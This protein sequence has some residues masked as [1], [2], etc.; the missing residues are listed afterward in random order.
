MN[1]D[2]LKT[3]KMRWRAKI[4]PAGVLKGLLR[5]NLS[6]CLAEFCVKCCEVMICSLIDPKYA[7]QALYQLSYDPIRRARNL[8]SHPRLSNFLPSLQANWAHPDTATDL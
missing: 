3:F 7:I 5:L 8:K 1:F 6:K 4:S 2:P